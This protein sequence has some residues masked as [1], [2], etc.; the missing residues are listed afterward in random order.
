[1]VDLCALYV[2]KASVPRITMQH[3]VMSTCLRVLRVASE[4][5]GV[6]QPNGS[7]DKVVDFLDLPTHALNRIS[8]AGESIA[9]LFASGDTYTFHVPREYVRVV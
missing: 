6:L 4:A 3:T 2:L 7:L 1:M 5:D 8:R 9:A